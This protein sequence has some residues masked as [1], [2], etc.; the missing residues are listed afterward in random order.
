MV[1]ISETRIFQADLNLFLQKAKQKDVRLYLR[2]VSGT[3]Y[4]RVYIMMDI[5]EDDERLTW[6][7]EVF[8]NFSTDHNGRGKSME[9]AIED[10]T[11]VRFKLLKNGFAVENGNGMDC[12]NWSPCEV[13][14]TTHYFVQNVAVLQ[15]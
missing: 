3:H 2:E 9:L 10:L 6:V 1:S 13:H 8:S 5:V 4:S 12:K 11:Q 7:Y 15:K 14:K